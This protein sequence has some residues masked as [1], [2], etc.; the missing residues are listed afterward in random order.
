MDVL[1]EPD[2][3]LEAFSQAANV[4]WCKRVLAFPFSCDRLKARGLDADKVQACWPVINFQRFHKPENRP[5]TGRVMCNGAAIWK[6]AHTDFIDLAVMMRGQS[7]LKFDL[8]AEGP[9]KKATQEYNKTKGKP[10]NITYVDPE[11]MPDIYSR[12]DWLV[13]PSDP[14]INKVG[15]PV[16]IAE[17]HASGVGV[18]WQELPRRRQEQIEYLGGAGFLFKSLQ[19]LPDI[20]SRPYPEEM[21][22]NGFEAAKRCDIQGHKHLLADVWNEAMA[23][24]P[25]QALKEL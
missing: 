5:P 6:K 22:L 12:Y 20:L 1:S 16:G 11:E 15:L 19:E 7:D 24:K 18:C 9:S 2:N 21:R 3:K 23:G 10:V 4:L 14:Q 8:Y 17:A 13:Y 25:A